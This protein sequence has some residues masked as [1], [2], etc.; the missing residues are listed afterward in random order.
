MP[1]YIVSALLVVV[2]GVGILTSSVLLQIVLLFGFFAVAWYLFVVRG[3]RGYVCPGCKNLLFVPGVELGPYCPECGQKELQPGS[4]AYGAA[5]RLCNGCGRTLKTEKTET[6]KTDQR[7]GP[8]F[9]LNACSQCG[10]IL[11]DQ[12]AQPTEAA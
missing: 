7:L 12:A 4:T 1:W 2:V 8:N 3:T 6:L 11:V 9:Q 5:G 10:L